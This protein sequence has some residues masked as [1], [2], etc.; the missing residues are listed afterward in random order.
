MSKPW[1]HSLSSARR[2]GGKPEDY[3]EI[4]NLMDS[5]KAAMSSNAH[6][7]LT[8]SHV[9]VPPKN[10][11]TPFMSNVAHAN[12][13]ELV[14]FE[15]GWLAAEYNKVP[16]VSHA[17]WYTHDWAWDSVDAFADWAKEASR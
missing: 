3:I 9:F 10:M 13:I 5:S 7:A 14:R 1:I 6:R 16:P 11:W 12:D 17:L 8:H 15:D 2:F 4:H